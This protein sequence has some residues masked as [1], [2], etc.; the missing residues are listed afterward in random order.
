MHNHYRR[1]THGVQ[2]AGR[3]FPTVAG[4][5]ATALILVAIFVAV[6]SGAAPLWT[7]PLVAM[8]AVGRPRKGRLSNES[9]NTPGAAPT[10]NQRLTRV[11]RAIR[12]EFELLIDDADQKDRRLSAQEVRDLQDAAVAIVRERAAQAGAPVEA[13]EKV[14]TVDGGQKPADEL[15]WVMIHAI[16]QRPEWRHF[17]YALFERTR[18]VDLDAD[19]KAREAGP[20]TDHAVAIAVVA[21]LLLDEDTTT[22]K[23]ALETVLSG[24]P[25]VQWALG[26]PTVRRCGTDYRAVQ[27]AINGRN[28]VPLEPDELTFDAGMLRS[29]SP[30]LWRDALVRVAKELEL[31]FDD[32]FS[33]YAGVDGT[34]LVVR[35]DQRPGNSD[36]DEL[37]LDGG[38]GTAWIN[39]GDDKKWRGFNLLILTLFRPAIP[40]GYILLGHGDKPSVEHVSLGRLL[41]SVYSRW[42][43]IDI[44]VLAADK[45]YD[46]KPTHRL[47]ELG[48]AI[49]PAF[50]H[51]NHL[52]RKNSRGLPPLMVANGW[53]LVDGIPCP[54]DRDGTPLR[55]IEA[56]GFQTPAKRREAG[57][58]PGKIVERLGGNAPRLRYAMPG[59]PKGSRKRKD[60]RFLDNP[61][62]LPYLPLVSSHKRHE[63]RLAMLSQRNTAEMVNAQSK[64]DGLDLGARNPR[65]INTPAAMGHYVGA[66]MFR[67]AVRKLLRMNDGYGRS[68]SEAEA[69][70]LLLT[71]GELAIEDADAA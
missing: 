52:K 60:F 9:D 1:S 10:Q 39:Q 24:G 32:D 15:K 37:E 47:C 46:N 29:V 67:H 45:A 50:I 64:L 55:L 54:V 66:A 2:P 28:V 33:S 71:G 8:A 23:G 4:I 40:V 20:R 62:M 36:A 14:A 65:W 7:M 30:E 61:G 27:E 12:R 18:D 6:T 22:M 48:Y 70:G 35:R 59:A 3:S 13:V 17:E 69:R 42:E 26:L 38:L 5:M 58:K 56:D 44:E 57:L 43:D 51:N 63:L 16:R 21:L 19:L 11:S 49:R 34:P 68:L 25:L 41:E 53:G 31:L